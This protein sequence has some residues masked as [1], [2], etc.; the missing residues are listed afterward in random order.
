MSQTNL[1][2]KFLG[3]LVGLAIGDALGSPLEFKSR[4]EIE[5]EY[6]T[7]VRDYLPRSEPEL[8]AGHEEVQLPTRPA[9]ATTEDTQLSLLLAE[10]LIAKK[11][12]LD[13]AH[14]GPLLTTVLDTALV[15]FLGATS[16]EALQSAKTTGEYSAGGEGE[17][18]AGNGVATRIAAI[19]L[20]HA[21]GPFE[22]EKFW[23]D[24][25]KVAWLTHRNPVAVGAGIGVA[26]AI[27]LMA[28]GE[29]MPED[30][31]AAALDILPPGPAL[32][33]PMSGNPLHQKLLAAQDFI[34]ERQTLVDNV[35]SGDLSVDFFRIDLNNLERCGLTSYAPQTLAAAFYAFAARKDSFEEAVTLAINA[36]GDTDG[37]GSITGA[38][39]GAYHGLSGIPEHWCKG[40]LNYQR[41]IM[42][43]RQL[44]EV[45]QKQNNEA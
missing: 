18:S 6:K 45:V 9:G 27:R 17:R 10:S 34:E 31:M 14:F 12:Q 7:P 11:G 35:D 28:R 38:I 43:A 21:Y 24:C 41:V 19:G 26:Q 1:E 32:Q 40:L 33:L 13:P 2:D 37:I 5:N 20:L 36:G 39:A 8:V 3:C 44:H 42:V 25:K 29:I 16:Y 22:R 30:L 15:E 4:A 23:D